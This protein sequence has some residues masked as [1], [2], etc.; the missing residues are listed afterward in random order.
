M[1]PIPV[2]EF[3]Y[4]ADYGDR[5]EAAAIL[6]RLYGPKVKQYMLGRQQSTLSWRLRIIINRIQ[7][8]RKDIPLQ[9]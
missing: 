5:D 3:T 6:G 7:K 1:S 2:H 8:A 4:V 9:A